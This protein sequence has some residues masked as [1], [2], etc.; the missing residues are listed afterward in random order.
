MIILCGGRG[1]RMGKFTNKIPKPMIKIGGKPIIEHKIKYYQ[2]RGLNKFIFC[3]GYKA[4][5][6]KKFLLKKTKNS[7]FNNGGI[8]AGI[9]KRIFF[10]P[11]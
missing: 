10:S 5:I 8:K 7:L 3:L 2:S 11:L 6:L 4:N 9:L 1:K